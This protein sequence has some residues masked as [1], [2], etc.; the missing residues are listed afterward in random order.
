METADDHFLYKTAVTNHAEYGFG[1]LDAIALDLNDPRPISMRLQDFREP[2]HA[3][4]L[5]SEW[6]PGR[7]VEAIPRIDTAQLGG[8]EDTDWSRRI[9]GPIERWIVND[10]G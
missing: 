9:R 8:G 10:D 7:F 1:G 4:A 3:H 2:R 5:P 6:K